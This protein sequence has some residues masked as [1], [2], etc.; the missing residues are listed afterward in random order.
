MLTYT[1]HTTIL[2][3]QPTPAND[4]E[5]KKAELKKTEVKTKEP[6]K[7]VSPEKKVEPEPK[8]PAAKKLETKTKEPE[9]IA[10][11]PE[12]KPEIKAAKKAEIKAPEIVEPEE[13]KRKPSATK[14]HRNI[15]RPI[16]QLI[17]TFVVLSITTFLFS[18][19]SFLYLTYA[20]LGS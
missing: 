19:F 1:I 3:I 10:K 9:T 15:F 17:P 6:L 12:P 14:V 8:T 11:E 4:V 7:K 5:E 18:F 2:Y 20:L 13:I 16:Y